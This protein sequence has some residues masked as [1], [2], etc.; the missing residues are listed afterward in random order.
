MRYRIFIAAF[1][2]AALIG[3]PTANGAEKSGTPVAP[4]PMDKSKTT[5][6]TGSSSPAAAGTPVAPSKGVT[7]PGTTDPASPSK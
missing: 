5:G 3:T 6:K 2:V 4:T 1:A 7:K